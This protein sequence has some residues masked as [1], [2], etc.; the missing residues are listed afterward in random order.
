MATARKRYLPLAAATCRWL[1]L[2]KH[3]QSD[4]PDG[5][6]IMALAPMG[7]EFLDRSGPSL[8]LEIGEHGADAAVQFLFV[9]EAELGEDR[10]DVFLD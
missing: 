2:A 7:Q 8:V 4:T 1:P 10:G 3:L 5:L 6:R 9:G